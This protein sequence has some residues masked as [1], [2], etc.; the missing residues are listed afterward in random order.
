MRA[1][2]VKGFSK[3]C[4]SEQFVWATFKLTCE[5]L[6]KLRY[7]VLSIYGNH[8]LGLSKQ[9]HLSAFVL[10]LSYA[11]HCLVKAKI[12]EAS[13]NVLLLDSQ[14]IVRHI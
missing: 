11:Y 14:L 3:L 4:G 7:K 2:T 5:D 1:P 10:S 6:K 8:E 9:L 12:K 13:T